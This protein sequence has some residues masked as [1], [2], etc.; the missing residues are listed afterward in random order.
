MT[1]APYTGRVA[2]LATM[3]GKEAAFAPVL[4]ERLGLNL[5]VPGGIDTDALGTF[6]GEVARP[7]S[8]EETATAKAEL[9]LSITGGGLALASEGAYGPRPHLP[10]LPFGVEVV[11]WL[12]RRIGLT[13][14]ERVFDDQPV[15]DHVVLGPGE[16]PGAFLGRIG[17]PDQK[18][19][20]RPGDQPTGACVA[21]GIGS[22]L[23]L[24]EAVKRARRLSP[25][26]KVFVQTDMRAH[27]N[28]R[29]MET[30]ARL[31]RKLASRLLS[32]C[33]ACDAPGF[34][35]TSFATGLPCSWCGRPTLMIRAETWTCC[36]CEYREERPRGDGLQ[37]AD[38]ATCPHC[39]P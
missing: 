14:L 11:A 20:L 26:G 33:P 21:K 17:F 28:P 31:A 16:D 9:G 13:L 5:I 29:R 22:R 35:R 25:D 23:K 10:F 37:E 15:F 18:V 24:K 7:G 32:S 8:I 27:C 19:I 12:D 3:H 36:A 1:R 2:V 30:L 4:A 34:G 6:T 39:N 38:P